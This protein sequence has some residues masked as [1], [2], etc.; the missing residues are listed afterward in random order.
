MI[1]KPLQF[2]LGTLLVV[3]VAAPAVILRLERTKLE[4]RLAGQREHVQIARRLR[5]ENQSLRDLVA[6]TGGD[7]AAAASNVHADLVAAQRELAELE[8][9]AHA[10]RSE[11]V[12]Q[13]ARDTNELATNRDP[14][15][16]LVRLE[17]FAEAGQAT[18]E[19]AFQS[20]VAAVMHNRAAR[21][22]EL[23]TLSPAARAKAD[24]LIAELPENARA[25]WSPEKLGELFLT[26]ALTSASAVQIT[27][28]QPRDAQ[29][30]TLVFRIPG[31]KGDPKLPLELGA[32]G[33]RVL[34][35]GAGIDVVRK[36]ID[37][38]G[39]PR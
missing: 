9:R 35:D 10:R 24:A 32:G 15:R 33:W 7:T 5:E 29:H 13:A 12:A 34:I 6:K 21:L 19:A 2:L 31:A 11:V 23:Y 36:H 25:Q 8:K 38:A 17:N 26:G 20:L 27:D 18:P 16:G 14:R 39:E 4:R 37:A 22:A 28:V 30:A 3:A 1:S